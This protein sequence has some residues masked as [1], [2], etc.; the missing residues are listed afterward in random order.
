MINT[1]KEIF[2]QRTC[3]NFSDK[4]LSDELLREIYDVTKLGSSSANTSPLRIIFIRSDEAKEKLINCL[5]P[6]NKEKTKHAPVI[7]IFA[8]DLDFYKYMDILF[9]HNPMMKSM[10]ENNKVL[11]EDTAYRNSTLQAAYFMIVAK[12][13]GLDCG[14]MSGF[15]TEMVNRTFLSEENLKVNFLCNLGYKKE[16]N[17]FPR[18][19]RLDFSQAC[20]II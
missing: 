18:S 8:Y 17:P 3:Y 10:F 19:P 20:K 13:Y 16:P 1:I 4:P 7:A 15:D 12:A 6:A 2:N 5:A 14:P 9:P 11:S